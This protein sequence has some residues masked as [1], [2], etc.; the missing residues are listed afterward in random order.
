MELLCLCF[1]TEQQTEPEA[2]SSLQVVKIIHPHHVGIS[3]VCLTFIVHHFV[4]VLHIAYIYTE[5]YHLGK[6]VLTLE[7]QPLTTEED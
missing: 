5:E 1:H 6:C 3:Q 2:C 4:P 7:F